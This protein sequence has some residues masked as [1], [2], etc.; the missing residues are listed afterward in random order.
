MGIA[1]TLQHPAPSAFLFASTIPS[2]AREAVLVMGLDLTSSL[3]RK[4]Q[5]SNCTDIEKTN[6]TSNCSNKLAK[7]ELHSLSTEVEF[8]HGQSYL[9]ISLE[10]A[11]RES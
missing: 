5:K 8:L 4:S 7:P 9:G 6:T 11:E 3:E 1:D 2:M 10:N